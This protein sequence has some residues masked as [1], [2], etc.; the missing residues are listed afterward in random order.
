MSGNGMTREQEFEAWLLTWLAP[1]ALSARLRRG[2]CHVG[3]AGTEVPDRRVG[4]R[5]EPDRD[6][7]EDTF[8][9]CCFSG[10]R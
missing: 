10:S 4:R 5:G 9:K 8:R 2:L 7:E 3:M 6:W 1:E